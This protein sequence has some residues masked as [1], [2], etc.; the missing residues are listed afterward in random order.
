MA[1]PLLRIEKEFTIPNELGIHARPATLIV[2]RL[3][4][5]DVSVTIR[6]GDGPSVNGKSVMDVLML[7]A[8]QGDRLLFVMEGAEADQ[9]LGVIEELFNE[10]FYES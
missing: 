7:A 5:L 9:A 1:E 4:G 2:K 8:E 6:N 3:K 10:S